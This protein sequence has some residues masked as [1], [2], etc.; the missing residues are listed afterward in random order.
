MGLLQAYTTRSF[1]CLLP[2]FFLPQLHSDHLGLMAPLL[3]S[4]SPLRPLPV[5]HAL[6]SHSVP[7]GAD[8]DAV[9]QLLLKVRFVLPLCQPR[10][11]EQL[12]RGCLLPSTIV[13]LSLR[14]PYDTGSY[15]AR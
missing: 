12:W 3:H 13:V 2:S 6:S 4:L 11:S 15:T 1:H 8:G 7:S 5:F 14:N 10:Q 9:S